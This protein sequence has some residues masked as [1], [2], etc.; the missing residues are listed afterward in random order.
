MNKKI[1]LFF[2]LL[3][4]VSCG[5][6]KNNLY[7]LTIN[8]EDIYVGYTNGFQISTSFD[9]LK[10]DDKGVITKITLYP[11]DYDSSIAINGIEI[12]DS[13]STNKDIYYGY[14]SNGACV[15]EK[16]ISGKTNRIIFYNNILNDDLV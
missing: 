13:I 15:V 5:V 2:C 7:K 16:K 4:L 8:D 10:T 14:I 6:N 3:L 12:D 11:K 9:E 1:L